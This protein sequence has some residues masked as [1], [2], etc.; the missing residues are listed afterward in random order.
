MLLDFDMISVGIIPYLV[1]TNLINADIILRLPR[2]PIPP[3]RR[4]FN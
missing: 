2:K 1:I 4:T 3:P